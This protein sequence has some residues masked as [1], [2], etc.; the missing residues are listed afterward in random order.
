MIICG[1]CVLELNGSYI[2]DF[3]EDYQNRVIFDVDI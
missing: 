1:I 3:A 2:S